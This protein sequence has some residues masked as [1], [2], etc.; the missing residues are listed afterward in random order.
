MNLDKYYTKEDCVNK[1]V[2]ITVDIFPNVKNYV[3]PSAGSGNITNCLKEYNFNVL[4]YDI[5]PENDDIIK[6]D[7][8]NTKIVCDKHITIGNPPF[9]YKGDLAIKFL[10]KALYESIAVAFIMPITA[11]KYS[12]Q[13]Q[14]NSDAILIYQENLPENSFELPNKQDYSCPCVFQ[15]WMLPSLFNESLNYVNLR[16]SKPLNKYK[17]FELYRHNA[18][19]SSKKYIDYDW[20]F[21]LYAQGWKDYT[22]IF[23]KKDY[24]F[25]KERINNSNDQ[26]YFI[27]ANNTIVLNNL[28]KIDYNELAHKNHI[29]PG[30]CKNDIIKKYIELYA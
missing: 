27:K 10:N 4:S 12:F 3:E 2:K 5:L 1:I 6:A 24:E 8:L 17:D 28:L 13:K 26:F 20:D 18:T 30:F 9:G 23:Y 16:I 22:K 25:L 14:I 15:I 21:A 11:L 7:Y 19:F 29:I